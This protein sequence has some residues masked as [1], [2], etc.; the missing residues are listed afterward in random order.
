METPVLYISAKADGHC[1]LLHPKNRKKFFDKLGIS[2]KKVI[3]MHLR[4]TSKCRV[5]SEKDGGKLF[6]NTDALVASGK[7]VF[8]ALPVGDCLPIM[9]YDPVCEIF[10]VIHA[11]WRG[12][13]GGVIRGAIL[14]MKKE[15]SE[16]SNLTVYIGASICQKHYEVKNDVYSKFSE[17]PYAV[18]KSGKKFYL[19]LGKV[20]VGQLVEA[21]VLEEKIKI[22][23]R[24]TY[25][26]KDLFSYRRGDSGR[27]LY[28][29]GRAV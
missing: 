29:F 20:A 22:D 27:N 1:G 8:L 21:G 28:L 12:L 19:D 26:D 10:G 11:G 23:K 18:K 25:E 6:E 16:P 3:S 15:G 9:I 14:K 5:V 4:H 2:E 7:G 17:Y 13:A 24:C